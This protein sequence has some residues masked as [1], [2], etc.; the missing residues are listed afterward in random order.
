MTSSSKS[1][2]LDQTRRDVAILANPTAGR[3]GSSAHVADLVSALRHRGL[4]PLL[5]WEREELSDVLAKCSEG[6][7]CVVAAGGDG[8]LAEVL[9][10][11]PGLPVTL[12]PLGNENLVARYFGLERSG[13]QVALTVAGGH[14]KV[15]D[16]ARLGERPVSLMVGVGFDADVVHQVHRGRE[17]HISRLSYVRPTLQSFLRYSFPLFEAVIG[18]TGERLGGTLALV[19]NLPCYGLDLPLAPEARGEDGWLDLHLFQR[20]GRWNLTRYLWAV[21][22]GRQ[23]ELPGCQYRRVR[24]VRFESPLGVPVQAD[25]D[26]AGQ[27]PATV[28]AVPAALRLVVPP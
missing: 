6:L 4:N 27:L 24:S 2:T 14:V 10:R 21:V 15:L 28:E 25:G 8:T 18:E 11:A 12:L 17:G 19:F 1:I 22:S 9:T 20:P 16:L 26:P 3:R 13:E 5:C 23:A 7:R